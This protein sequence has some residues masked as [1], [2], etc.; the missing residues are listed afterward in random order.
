LAISCGATHFVGKRGGRV[1][2]IKR[3]EV[4]VTEIFKGPDGKPHPNN[5]DLK[6]SGVQSDSIEAT[7]LLEGEAGE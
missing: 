4:V 6:I 7:D 3:D 2:Q 5:I 1:T